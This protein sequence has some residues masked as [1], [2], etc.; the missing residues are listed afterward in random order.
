MKR[1]PSLETLA[2]DDMA[3]LRDIAAAPRPTGSE[4]IARA[5]ERCVRELR[6][7]GYNINEHHFT[8]SEFPGRFGTPLIGG[9]AAAIV[10]VAGQQGAAGM[11][12]APLLTVATGAIVLLIA[13]RWLARRGVL[14]APV[15]R[16]K[17]INIEATREGPEPLIWIAAHLDSKS[18]PIPTLVRSLGIVVEG[19]GLL[20]AMALAVAAASGARID[21]LY[22][23]FAAM[24]TLVGALPVVFSVV[25]SRSPGALDNASG[26]ATVIAAA[27]QLGRHPGLGILIT[28]AE[29]LGLAGA[30]AWAIEDFPLTML[31][32]D[33]VD[34]TGEI[35]VMFTGH[36]PTRLLDAVAR[37]SAASDVRHQAGRLIPGILTDSVAFTDGGLE[38]VTFSRG[39]LKSLTRVHSRR[40]NLANLRG[41]GIAETATLIA[42]TVRELGDK[43]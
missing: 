4:A 27:R 43:R 14:D 24:V 38:S 19:L 41:T 30:R 11:R 35:Q 5:R 34:D 25:G 10:G 6:D 15:L 7:L 36:R 26:I 13:G 18:Q 37:A 3:L 28:D 1:D 29:E 9:A 40:D 17:G 42:A 20:L 31:N 21:S 39:S 32:C 2:Q 33:G 22:W 23:G 16:A 12:I 8:F